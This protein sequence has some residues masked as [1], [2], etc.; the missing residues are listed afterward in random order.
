[1]CKD[2]NGVMFIVELQTYWEYDWFQRCVCYSSR[3]YDRQTKKGEDYNVPPVYL[4]AFMGVNINHPDKE[5]WR[6]RYISEYTFREKQSHD[7]LAETIVIIFAELARF[8]KTAEECLTETDQMLYVL[9]N[10]G[11]LMEQPAWLRKEV[12]DRILKG[13]E[14]AGFNEEKRKIYEQEMNDEKRR[15]SQLK[16]AAMMGREEGRAE[17]VHEA[18]LEA[19]K[20]FKSLGV[21]EEIISQATGLPIETIQNL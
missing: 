17:G 19:A 6:D 4:I 5:F 18:K 11:R 14:I 7:L 9:R 13:C 12:F 16:T 3:A 21:S 2:A 8:T 20:N 15:N 10:I 1:M